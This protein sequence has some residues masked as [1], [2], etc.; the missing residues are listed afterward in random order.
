M[1]LVFFTGE[2]QGMYGSYYYARDVAAAGED[3]L[4][5][6]N[7]DMIAWDAKGGPDIDLHSQ[8]P[9]VEDDSDA[10]AGL[11]GA[12]V[13]LYG[14]NLVPQIVEAG[15]RFSDHSRFWDRGYPAIM[16]IEDYYNISEQ[17][18]EPRDWNT[19][20][21]TA[22][23]RLATLNLGYFREYVRA[24]VATLLHLARP[25]RVVSGTVVGAGASALPGAAVSIAGQNGSFGGLTD[26]T[27]TY[28]VPVPSGRYTVTA[29]A[30]GYVPQS[31]RDVTVLSGAGLRLDFVL[32]PMPSFVVSGT[33]T[34]A[35]D[36]L[37]LSATLH[38]G[39][40]QAILA[41]HGFYHTTLVSGTHVVTVRARYHYPTT[42]TLLV[43]QDQ[44]QDFV[45]EPTPCLLVVDDDYDTNGNRY[46][47][48]AYYTATLEALGL[49]Y[50]VWAVPDN[51]DGPP[52]SVLSLYRGVVWL[53]GRDW[54]HTLTAA[55]QAALTGFL[56]GGGRL[57]LS[58]QDI[59]W[60]L[61][62]NGAPPFY[63]DILHAEYLNDDSEHHE[64]V[65]GA[66]M[67]GL[68]IT[69]AGGDG[70]DNQAYPSEIGAL[71]EALD[72]FHYSDNGATAAIAVDS[73][74]H[75]LVYLAFGFEAINSASDR[76]AVMARV[77]DYLAICPPYGVTLAGPSIGF[78]EPGELVTHRLRISNTGLLTD[79]YS[80]SV[81][82][83]PA[84]TTTLPLTRTPLLPGGSYV[85][86]LITVQ[87]P[88]DAVRGDSDQF[89]LAV[90]SVHSP[91]LVSHLTLRTAVG[92]PVYVPFVL[93]D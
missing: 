19:N 90:T 6:L 89:T 84:W 8:L 1:R 28:A 13:D 72:L 43:H 61:A 21:H 42:R 77:R 53:T 87:V 3:I 73:T 39:E 92:Y 26:G 71:G 30:P 10:L 31:V 65:G 15:A 58:G 67:A 41:P 56:A 85:T 57:L 49:P 55:D 34:S 48:Q 12:V 44:R 33:V 27:G 38:F 70:A 5:V 7:L 78:G 29:S 82:G 35:N 81:T 68:T 64:L 2:E 63:S 83:T 51:H 88:L 9:S 46:D 91:T 69:I 20:Y 59:G 86:L 50:D 18:Y 76:R 93:A 22:N 16:A 47:D 75:R 36:G 40:G 74:S 17:P 11:F 60:D 54:D 80:L 45:L 52:E 37:P 24:S 32:A 62:R 14:L 4:G 25:M 66:F 79:A 23:D